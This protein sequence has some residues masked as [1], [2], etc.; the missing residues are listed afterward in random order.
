MAYGTNLNTNNLN[1]SLKKLMHWMMAA[2][3]FCGL[4]VFYI[5]CRWQR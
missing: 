4:N 3:L 1:K 2:I 5:M